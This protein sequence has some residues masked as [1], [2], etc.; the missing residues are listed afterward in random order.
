MT[1]NM[2]YVIAI[3]AAY[4]LGSISPSAILAKAKGIDI[5]KEGS[6]NP[7]TTNTLRVLGVKAAAVTLLVDVLKGVIAVSI[8]FALTDQTGAMWCAFAAFMGHLYPVEMRFK[9][10]K[11]VAVAFG[12]LLRL[13]WQLGIS[14]LII[15]VLAVLITRKV[16]MGSV[17][18]ACSFPFL[19]W[20]MYPDFIYIGTVMAIFVL[21]RHRG[22]IKRL[23]NHEER[24]I[25]FSKKAFNERTG[26]AVKRQEAE[27]AEQ[28]E[29]QE[30]GAEK[31]TAEENSQ[32]QE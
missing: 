22:N 6:G 27:A 31:I 11:G 7:G 26:E 29:G 3:A 21:I 13:H 18:A 23:I 19:C 1:Q 15:V 12:V 16:S 4:F 20:Y 10:G 28:S 17:I 14:M 8:G 2:Y 5:H 25:S 24:S 30:A 9:G 32:D